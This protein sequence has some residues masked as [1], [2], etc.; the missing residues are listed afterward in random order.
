MV[1]IFDTIIDN[2]NEEINCKVELND[3]FFGNTEKIEKLK[4]HGYCIHDSI[5]ISLKAY[6]SAL[7][8]KND[9]FSINMGFGN[10]LTN[11]NLQYSL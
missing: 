1:Y 11:I 9:Y 10:T 3:L 7:Y 8:L 2:E 4:K 5:D 6:L